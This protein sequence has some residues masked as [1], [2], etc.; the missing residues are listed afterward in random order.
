[1]FGDAGAKHVMT[2]P[3]IF[4]GLSFPSSIKSFV[5]AAAPSKTLL[6]FCCAAP[7]CSPKPR[8]SEGENRCVTL[9]RHVLRHIHQIFSLAHSVNLYDRN[10]KIL[11][12][13][14]VISE[15]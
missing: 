11:R 14:L 8:R 9:M 1:M 12:A 4:M 2:F 3:I 6:V 5:A 10:K 13:A 15:K 7:G